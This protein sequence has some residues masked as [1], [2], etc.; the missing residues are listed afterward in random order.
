MNVT[1]WIGPYLSSTD[2]NSY[3]SLGDN[4]HI[5]QYKYLGTVFPPYSPN[6]DFSISVSYKFSKQDTTK[7]YIET[8]MIGQAWNLGLGMD[9]PFILFN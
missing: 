6:L 8:G 5:G 4:Y 9:M 2:T 7:Y 3:N 1:T